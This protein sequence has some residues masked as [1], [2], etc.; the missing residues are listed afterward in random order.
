MRDLDGRI[1]AVLVDAPCTGT[2]TWR[3]LARTPNGACGRGSLDTRRQEQAAVLDR[4]A[5]L[6]KPSGRIVYV[7]CSILPE[8]NDEA[9][10]GFLERTPASG[11]FPRRRCWR[12]PGSTI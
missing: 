12:R 2:G 10:A 8:E 7:T 3:R 4:A 6:W 9:V 11:R 5:R 1:D